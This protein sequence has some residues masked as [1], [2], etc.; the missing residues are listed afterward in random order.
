MRHCEVRQRD[1]YD[2]V[3][4]LGVECSIYRTMI[5][6]VCILYCE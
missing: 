1:S 6:H 5:D 3:G 2:V 4:G